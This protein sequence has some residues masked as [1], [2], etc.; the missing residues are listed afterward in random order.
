MCSEEQPQWVKFTSLEYEKDRESIYRKRIDSTQHEL[1]IQLQSDIIDE[2]TISSIKW[3]LQNEKD[4]LQDSL[5]KQVYFI[6][7]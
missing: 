4:N 1:D 3:L 5:S 6:E 7:K 2:M